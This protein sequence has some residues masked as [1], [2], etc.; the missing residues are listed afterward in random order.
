M[1]IFTFSANGLDINKMI[2]K[3]SEWIIK[4]ESICVV[5]KKPTL[6]MT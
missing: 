3:L 5:Y 4:Q 2:D 6:N 1:S